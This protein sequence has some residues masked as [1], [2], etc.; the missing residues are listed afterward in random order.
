MTIL[1]LD[2]PSP[3]LRDGRGSTRSLLLPGH[4]PSRPSH[5]RRRHLWRRR[6]LNNGMILF[7]AAILSLLKTQGAAQAFTFSGSTALSSG[8]AVTR[9]LA[10]Q[11]QPRADRGVPSR[12]R[13]MMS[14]P[15][16]VSL[17][18]Q[19]QIQRIPTTALRYRPLDERD[20][21]GDPSFVKV[22]SKAPSFGLYD[23]KDAIRSVASEPN[24]GTKELQ[25]S[26]PRVQPP[27]GQ[28]TRKSAMNVALIRAL[29]LNQVRDNSEVAQVGV[30]CFLT[31]RHRSPLSH[32]CTN[33]GPDLGPRG[34]P[35]CGEA[36]SRGWVPGPRPSGRGVEL[37]RISRTG[38]L[39]L[40]RTGPVGRRGRPS[41]PG[42]QQPHRELRPGTS[43]PTQT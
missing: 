24:D 11:T 42:D 40:L 13:S 37:G 2:D 28:P 21:E 19:H 41:A 20:D 25:R 18:R 14:G 22:R 29:E 34:D 30:R 26:S 1:P 8:A 12:Q 35:V 17:L 16:A 31:C 15:S 36:R 33:T 3:L 39:R 9:W 32:P 7:F 10:T 27:P 43:D 38:S 6:P 23:V 5:T 4:D